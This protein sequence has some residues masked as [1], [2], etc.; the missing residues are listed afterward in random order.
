MWTE[1]IEYSS[2]SVWWYNKCLI[3]VIKQKDCYT[4]RTWNGYFGK[5]LTLKEAK[6]ESL[7]YMNKF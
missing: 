3:Y 4:W 7:T 5:Q 1:T 6:E 2:I